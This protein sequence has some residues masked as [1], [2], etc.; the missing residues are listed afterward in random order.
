[1]ADVM[2]DVPGHATQDVLDSLVAPLRILKLARPIGFLERPEE[3]QLALGNAF[4]DFER[5]LH[6]RG[7]GVGE[8]S[9]VDSRS[10]VFHAAP[11]RHRERP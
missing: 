8:L 2:A 7:A 10:R 11:I 3:V 4:Q 1:M 6:G 9:L 5:R